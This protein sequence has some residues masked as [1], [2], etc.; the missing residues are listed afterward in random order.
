M[1]LAATADKSKRRRE[2]RTVCDEG[3][4]GVVNPN[5]WKGMRRSFLHLPIYSF[6][7]SFISS[8]LCHLL[9]DVDDELEEIGTYLKSREDEEESPRMREVYCELH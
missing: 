1:I 4:G 7:H 5:D 3:V 6:I 2:N 8:P 9:E